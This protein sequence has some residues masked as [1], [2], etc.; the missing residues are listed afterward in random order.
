MGLEQEALRNAKAYAASLNQL[1]VDIT[2]TAECLGMLVNTLQAGGTSA[3][4][5]AGIDTRSHK[6]L[7][8]FGSAFEMLRDV[9][10]D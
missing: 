8:A 6:A 7:E 4:I 3:E 5:M 9:L 10:E 1:H 2:R